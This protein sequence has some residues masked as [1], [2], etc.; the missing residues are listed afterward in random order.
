VRADFLLLGVVA[1]PEARGGSR[2]LIRE[3]AFD[4]AGVHG[5]YH[6]IVGVTARH[7]VARASLGGKRLIAC[8]EVSMTKL[9]YPTLAR[10]LRP[11][12][13]RP[14]GKL[15]SQSTRAENLLCANSL[16]PNSHPTNSELFPHHIAPNPF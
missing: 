14:F 8:H 4:V 1:D 6:L 13:F 7:G 11:V 3:C 12:E 16:R 5:R 9:E 2:D 15:V 10:L